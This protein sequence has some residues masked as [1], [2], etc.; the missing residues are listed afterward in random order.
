[1][2]DTETISVEDSKRWNQKFYESRKGTVIYIDGA[3]YQIVNKSAFCKALGLEGRKMTYED[4]Y[5][6]G[7]MDYA[8]EGNWVGKMI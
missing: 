7:G 4:A 8:E 6:I 3:K 1:M 5:R 2:K